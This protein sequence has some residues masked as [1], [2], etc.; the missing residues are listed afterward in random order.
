MNLPQEHPVT[1]NDDSV[2][3]C[4]PSPIYFKPKNSI[5]PRSDS[6]PSDDGGHRNCHQSRPMVAPIIWTE[7][8]AATGSSN[9]GWH[10]PFDTVISALQYH[11]AKYSRVLKCHFQST[12]LVM[13][14]REPRKKCHV[15]TS[16]LAF[17]KGNL[18]NSLFAHCYEPCRYHRL[19]SGVVCRDRHWGWPL[20]SRGAARWWGMVCAGLG[21]ADQSVPVV[22]VSGGVVVS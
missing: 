12:P 7:V 5:C 14:E 6:R 4:A 11:I 16:R 18:N 13:G 15:T 2:R 20:R 9:V 22:G 8:I 21:V 17:E 10:T 1:I 19:G 3:I